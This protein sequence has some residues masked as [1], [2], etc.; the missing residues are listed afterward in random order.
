M[1]HKCKV[2]CHTVNPQEMELLGIQE[3]EGRWL[4]FAIDMGVIN[5]IKMSTDEKGEPTYNCATIFCTDGN[6]FILDT[7]YHDLV[8][9]WEEYNSS[10]WD[11][12]PPK[13][14]ADL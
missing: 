8:D 2:Q 9:K 13:D 10:M 7:P 1:I 12:P 14:D 4:P 6:S 11:V 5:A 3:D